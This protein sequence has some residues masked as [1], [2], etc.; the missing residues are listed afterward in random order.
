MLYM[1][2]IFVYLHSLGGNGI[3]CIGKTSVG[4]EYV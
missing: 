4:S 1:G 3:D 2:N